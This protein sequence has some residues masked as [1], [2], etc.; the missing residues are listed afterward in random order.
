M[1]V[2]VNGQ[3]LALV[4]SETP[5][6][7]QCVSSPSP[8]PRKSDAG[9][10]RKR[11]KEYMQL[12]VMERV[13]ARMASG[14]TL[15]VICETPGMPDRRTVWLWTDE[16]SEVKKMY[17][18]AQKLQEATWADQVISIPDNITID[19]VEL[20]IPIE[21][22]ANGGVKRSKR[23]SDRINKAKLRT[24]NR[25]WLLARRDPTRYGVIQVSV[26]GTT[27]NMN[28]NNTITVINS[29]DIEDAV[30]SELAAQAADRNAVPVED[31]TRKVST[32]PVTDV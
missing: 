20:F 1:V 6:S 7:D 17:E 25:K 23:T 21:G 9:K 13:C 18:A 28:G 29:P 5:T 11:P 14:E 10:K 31:F 2:K 22:L 32:N 12:A 8:T 3:S 27:N 4:D 15:T 30:N 19:D 24:D 16:N 26:G